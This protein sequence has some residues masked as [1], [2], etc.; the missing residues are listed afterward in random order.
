M[1]LDLKKWMSKVMQ[2]TEIK[3]V[4]KQYSNVSVPSGLYVKIDSLSDL[5]DA[6][7]YALT[8]M[9]TK[10]W[11]GVIPMGVVLGSNGND[12]YVLGRSQGTINSMGVVYIFR[13]ILGGVLHSSIFKAFS[14]FRKG[15]GVDEGQYKEA[16][17]KGAEPHPAYRQYIYGFMDCNEFKCEQPEGNKFNHI[18]S[19]DIH[20][21]VEDSRM[22]SGIDTC[23]RS[24]PDRYVGW[25]YVH[26]RTVDN[27][28]RRHSFG[29]DNHI[30]S[31]KYEPINE[32]HIHRKGLFEGCANSITISERRWV[33]C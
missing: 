13:R 18:A 26:K 12:V 17:G 11:S 30:R 16:A 5:A 15:G 6:S 21:F 10:G 22:Q 9:Y 8:A 28:I 27:N 7:K 29:T 24:S 3:A 2:V 23:L 33:T 1:K 31:D 20:P 32:L 14:H 19:R 25:R 4:S